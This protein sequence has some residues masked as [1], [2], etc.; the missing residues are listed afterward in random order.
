M[1]QSWVSCN[2]KLFLEDENLITELLNFIG[3]MNNLSQS[4]DFSV[5]A[6]RTLVTLV[7]FQL[8]DWYQLSWWH[9]AQ[10]HSQELLVESE[11]LKQQILFDL[12]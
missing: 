5:E 4:L 10:Q 1:N 11:Y 3:K 6:T 12:H 9:R 7:V 8:N 2:Q